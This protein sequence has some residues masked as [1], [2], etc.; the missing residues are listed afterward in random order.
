MFIFIVVQ[1]HLVKRRRWL[2]VKTDIYQ[3]KY[4]IQYSTIRASIKTRVHMIQ[5]RHGGWSMG[6]ASSAG[7]YRYSEETN[8]VILSFWSLYSMQLQFPASVG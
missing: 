1:I 3:C 8:R 7:S 5:S 6:V 2:L 4:T